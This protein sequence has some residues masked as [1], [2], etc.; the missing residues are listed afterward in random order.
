MIVAVTLAINNL[1][2]PKIPRQQTVPQT[3]LLHN[4]IGIPVA[5]ALALYEGMPFSLDLFWRA[6]GSTALS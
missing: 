6:A 2:I 3:L 5:L 1:L 4:L